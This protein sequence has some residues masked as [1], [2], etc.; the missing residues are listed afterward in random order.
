MI[1]KL[2]R[3]Q[4]ASVQI[5]SP[6][7]LVIFTARQ[8]DG[9]ENR[10]RFPGAHRT[11]RPDPSG[12]PRLDTCMLPSSN[13]SPQPQ[14]QLSQFQRGIRVGSVFPRRSL[15]LF[16]SLSLSRSRVLAARYE[17]FS[18][19]VKAPEFCIRIACLSRCPTAFLLCSILCVRLVCLSLPVSCFCGD[20]CLLLSFT[21]HHSPFASFTMHRIMRL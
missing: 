10:V 8:R 14:S 13:S 7:R 15:A 20:Q 16:L 4:S 11:A 2:A 18:G 17:N 19:D 5:L 21:L 12:R 9:D 1:N 6:S 3:H